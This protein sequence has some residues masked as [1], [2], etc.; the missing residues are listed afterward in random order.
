MPRE[1]ACASA[2]ASTLITSMR[3]SARGEHILLRLP[4]MSCARF[5]LNTRNRI[6]SSGPVN[7]SSANRFVRVHGHDR[8]AGPGSA[9]YAHGASGMHVNNSLLR[10]VQVDPPLAQRR[11]Q[12]LLERVV[13]FED[14]E[15]PVRARMIKRLLKGTG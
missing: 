5:L 3:R 9:E 6:R 7:T 10:R 8:L 4:L 2:Q 15:L 12:H 1:R 11:I 14:N 13:V